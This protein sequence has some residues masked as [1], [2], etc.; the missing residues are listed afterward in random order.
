MELMLLDLGIPT[1][2]SHLESC[3]DLCAALAR[4]FESAR[5]STQRTKLA[6]RWDATLKQTYALQLLLELRERQER[7]AQAAAAGAA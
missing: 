7:E 4:D 6:F 1:L 2:K 3:Q 5:S